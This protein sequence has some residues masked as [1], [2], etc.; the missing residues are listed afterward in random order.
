MYGW[1]IYRKLRRAT[2]D[3]ITEDSF[4]SLFPFHL[5]WLPSSNAHDP[6]LPNLV[7]FLSSLKRGSEPNTLRRFV[8]RN[9]G[10]C[11]RYIPTLRYIVQN[12]D[13]HTLGQTSLTQ[14][15]PTRPSISENAGHVN[16]KY[17]S[18]IL[19]VK[20]EVYHQLQYPVVRDHDR[21]RSQPAKLP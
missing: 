13:L 10:K 15:K 2:A 8:R 17:K 19:V 11:S 5:A 7:P 20:H 4:H 1:Y 16:S 12:Q 6:P 14:P 9:Y 21:T 18:H 3:P